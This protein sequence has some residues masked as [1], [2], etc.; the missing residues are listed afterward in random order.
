MNAVLKMSEPK[1]ML[2]LG[3]QDDGGDNG[4]KH[5]G[6]YEAEFRHLVRINVTYLS[7]FL[8]LFFLFISSS[9]VFKRSSLVCEVSQAIYKRE[10]ILLLLRRG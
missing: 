3:F 1:C 7:L 8:F 9:F 5:Y 10:N 6:E 4:T 2:L